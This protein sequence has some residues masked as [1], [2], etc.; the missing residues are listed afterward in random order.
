MLQALLTVVLAHF[1][2]TLL[3]PSYNH[4]LVYLQLNYMQI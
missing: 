1:H 2:I 3:F 4:I